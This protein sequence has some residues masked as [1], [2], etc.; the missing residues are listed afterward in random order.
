M[1]CAPLFSVNLGYISSIFCIHN[2]E[3]QRGGVLVT[4]ENTILWSDLR[5]FT[6]HNDAL[7]SETDHRFELLQA[8]MFRFI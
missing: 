6:S 4:A 3:G 8:V 1:K 7:F 5:L 2:W